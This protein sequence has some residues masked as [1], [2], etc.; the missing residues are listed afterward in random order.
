MKELSIKTEE[1]IYLAVREGFNINYVDKIDSLKSVRT[2]SAKGASAPIHCVGPGKAILAAQYD[3]LREHMQDHLVKFTDNTITSLERLDEDVALTLKRG[4][5]VDCAEYRE[6]TY[7]FGSVIK[8]PNGE[9]IAAFGVSAPEVNLDSKRKEEI[10][11]AVR[12]AGREASKA[13]Q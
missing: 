12:D 11:I 9:V 2:W 6:H 3:V 1:T 10:G 5:S 8:G 13:I 7:S 4:Y